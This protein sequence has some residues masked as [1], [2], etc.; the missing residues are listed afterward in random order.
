[1]ISRK[2]LSGKQTQPKKENTFLKTKSNFFWLGNIFCWPESVFHWP[3]F[4]MVNKYRKV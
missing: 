3:A 4:L 1:V 2:P